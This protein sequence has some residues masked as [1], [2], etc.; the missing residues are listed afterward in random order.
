MFS[1]DSSDK[2]RR[3]QSPVL[4]SLTDSLNLHR[5]PWQSSKVQVYAPRISAKRIPGRQL[6]VVRPSAPDAATIFHLQRRRALHAV[7]AL[8]QQ[9]GFRASASSV[10]A[11]SPRGSTKTRFLV[12]ISIWS[13]WQVHCAVLSWRR[14]VV[15]TL[16]LAAFH[17][18]A[19]RGTVQHGQSS[20]D[21]LK[22]PWRR[23]SG[24]RTPDL[25]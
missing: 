2:T 1:L 5:A 8:T 9:V 10:L 13:L 21:H 24:A 4:A 3:K 22:L 7:V 12:V 23:H 16:S 11:T 15:H 17:L 20:T 18:Q 19:R 14:V 25:R 6:R